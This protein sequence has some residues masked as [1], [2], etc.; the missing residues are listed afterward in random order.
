MG[1]YLAKI[2]FLADSHALYDDRIYWKQA[3]SLMKSGYEVFYILAGD[4]NESGT[5][6]EG[7]KFEIIRKDKFPSNPYINY[8]TKRMPGGLYAKMFRKAASLE[9]DVYHIHDL[10]VNRI[11]NKLKKLSFKPK[12][13]YDVHEP[14][15]ENI[16]DYWEGKGMLRNFRKPW[17]KY[18]RK[19][20][21]RSITNYD[22]II[23]TEENMQ[24]RFRIYFPDKP[25]EI[26]YNYTNL[27]V[28][29]HSTDTESKEFDAI[30]TGG[31]TE[32]RGV[33]QILEAV[34]RVKKKKNDFNLLFL[35]HWFPFQLKKEMELF[36]K[37]NGLDNHVSMLNAVSYSEVGEYYRKSKIGLGIFL[38]ILTHHIILQ[39]KIFE[40]MNY[41]LPIICSNFGHIKNIIQ[42][43]QCGIEVNPEDPDE[44]A[45]GLL[46][47]LS[48][49]T[50]YS[51]MSRNGKQAAMKNYRWETMEKKLIKIYKKLL[52]EEK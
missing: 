40:Y 1:N 38:P 18:I 23:T 15:P 2:C 42:R 26:I 14:Y 12:V 44:I 48:D 17:S 34:K 33:W 9:A 51:K 13:I 41:G 37:D 31:I 10:K 43:H 45:E 32:F 16:L 29:D 39:I 8:I 36:I 4:V 46:N 6:A 24:E 7:L 25:V 49:E 22:L 20:E 47:L 5:T 27:A 21:K 52:S 35:G 3:I 19:W 30:Y 50:K 11:G 28:A